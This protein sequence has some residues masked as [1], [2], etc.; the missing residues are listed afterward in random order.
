MAN[1]VHSWS[2]YKHCFIFA[3]RASSHCKH[4]IGTLLWLKAETFERVPNPLFSRIVR[5]SAR[6]CS[7]TRLR[8]KRPDQL[9]QVQI[10]SVTSQENSFFTRPSFLLPTQLQ[11]L[12][13][14]GFGGKHFISH[15]PVFL[16]LCWQLGT[17]GDHT[18]YLGSFFLHLQMHSEREKERGGQGEQ[19][20][21]REGKRKR[22]GTW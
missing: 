7:F 11:E 2:F 17:L 10:P 1:K 4:E 22:Q 8:I 6:G 14:T 13:I 16:S 5:C 15:S 3:S 19:A 20:R 12:I 18:C 9:S 21:G